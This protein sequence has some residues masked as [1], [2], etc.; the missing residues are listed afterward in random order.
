MSGTYSC[1]TVCF[2]EW[3]LNAINDFFF[4]NNKIIDLRFT[5]IHKT[6]IPKFRGAFEFERVKTT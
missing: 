2:L 4:A 3:W 6:D 1:A 5:Y